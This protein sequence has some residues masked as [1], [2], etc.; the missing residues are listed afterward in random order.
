M[1]TNFDCLLPKLEKLQKTTALEK[2]INPAFIA[3]CVIAGSF[4]CHEN[5]R[6]DSGIFSS[7]VD[8]LAYATPEKREIICQALYN[9][10]RE[11][12]KSWYDIPF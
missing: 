9:R 12:P 6:F 8:V 3:E 7:F 4:E 2:D 10:L 5:K 11:I 1:N